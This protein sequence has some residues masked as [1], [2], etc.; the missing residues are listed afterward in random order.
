MPT[1]TQEAPELY[2]S[3]E[4]HTM[5]R[6]NGVTPNGNPVGGRWVLRAPDGS[7]IDCHQYRTDLAEHHGF[8]LI[9]V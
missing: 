1:L 2:R 3:A 4:G 6:E 9:A 8:N 5:Q 7:W